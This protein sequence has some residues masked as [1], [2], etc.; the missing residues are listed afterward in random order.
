MT[1]W[2]KRRNAAL[3]Y[4]LLALTSCTFTAGNLETN[5]RFAFPNSDVTV[6][7][8]P[9]VA[10]DVSHTYFI[11]QQPPLTK[12]Y[13]DTVEKALKDSDA[14]MLTNIKWVTATTVYPFPVPI[15][16]YS[17]HMEAV[18]VKADVFMKRLN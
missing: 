15:Y 8:N 12:I 5:D 4:P 17:L 10:E 7:Q 18:A 3:I 2:R 6:A 1:N 16:Q 9:N 14:T 11:W 13:G